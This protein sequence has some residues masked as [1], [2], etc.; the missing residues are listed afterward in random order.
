MLHTLSCLFTPGSQPTFSPWTASSHIIRLLLSDLLAL[1]SSQLSH[2]SSDSWPQVL[3]SNTEAWR[4][5]FIVFRFMMPLR[6]GNRPR[7]LCC[8]AGCS[9]ILLFI[10]DASTQSFTHPFIHPSTHLLIHPPFIHPSSI[11]PPKQF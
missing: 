10:H 1:Y 5:E 9:Y 7:S 3:S 4:R 11:H 6:L 8:G 2:F